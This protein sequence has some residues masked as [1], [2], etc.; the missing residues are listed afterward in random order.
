MEKAR[1]LRK[2]AEQR[3]ELENFVDVLVHDLKAP[4]RSVILMSGMMERSVQEGKQKEIVETCGIV[5]KA[6][7]RMGQLIEALYQYTQ[8]EQRVVFEA[9]SMEQVV[10]NSLLNLEH[11]IQER[12]AHVTHGELPV[13]C[14][15][16]PQLIQLLQNLVGNGI[17]YCDAK[18]PTIYVS[19]TTHEGG[20]W[21]FSVSDNG[22]GIPK[23]YHRRIFE[24][25]KRAC[26]ES[27]YEGTGLGL[28]TCRKIVERH[29]GSIWCDSKEGDGTTFFFTL[30]GAA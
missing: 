11:A 25:F 15:N 12:G 7:Q 4:I 3:E 2:V 10:T 22:I 20:I 1:L 21:L 18:I 8:R 30:P 23:E 5:G 9:V 17:K 16:S 26:N 13:V 14:G 28:A 27:K 19:A 6:A 24:P 29:H